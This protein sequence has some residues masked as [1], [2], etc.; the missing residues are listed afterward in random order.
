[1]HQIEH[2]GAEQFGCVPT[3]HVGG[4]VVG[5][6]QHTVGVDGEHG[7]GEMVDRRRVRTWRTS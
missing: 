6:A 4:G 3:E 7:V 5:V 1:M 2:G